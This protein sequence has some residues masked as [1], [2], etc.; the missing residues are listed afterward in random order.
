MLC[1]IYPDKITKMYGYLADS[2][3]LCKLH[4]KF[5]SSL[6]CRVVGDFFCRFGK[7]AIGHLL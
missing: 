7:I 4:T 3:H 6:Y 1:M 2:I 5:L